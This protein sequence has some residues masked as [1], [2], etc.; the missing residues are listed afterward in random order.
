M[1]CR[2]S[3]WSVSAG[4]GVSR[5]FADFLLTPPVHT[6]VVILGVRPVMMDGS[7]T[8]CGQRPCIGAQRYAR[9]PVSL[10]QSIGEPGDSPLGAFIEDSHAVVAVEVVCFA[11]LQYQLHAVLATLSVRDAGIICLR[12]GLTDGQPRTFDEISHLYG[13]TREQVRQITAKTM[14]KLRHPLRSHALRDYLD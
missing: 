13:L 12:F 8:F 3:A 14:T 7:A 6:F 10:D 5:R 11:L 9:E 4:A 1:T 2:G